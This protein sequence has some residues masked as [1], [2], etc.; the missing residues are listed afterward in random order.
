MKQYIIN[1]T[2]D[3]IKRHRLNTFYCGHSSLT[4]KPEFITSAKGRIASS[5]C[6]M[7]PSKLGAIL[8]DL[9]NGDVIASREELLEH[10][11]YAGNCLY[12]LQDLVATALAYVVYSR[13][14][15]ASKELGFP[16][17]PPIA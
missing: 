8:G 16:P 7:S 17:Y 2:N 14:G 6:R 10:L 1:L 13:L 15:P 5:I 12:T 4:Q 11:T 3:L 9:E